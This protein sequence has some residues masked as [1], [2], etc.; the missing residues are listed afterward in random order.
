MSFPAKYGY[1][2]R[3]RIV[4]AVGFFFLFIVSYLVVKV[5]MFPPSDNDIS[6]QNNNFEV[7]GL[8]LP[9]NLNFC[10]EKLP[11]N[12]YGIKRALEKEFFNNIYWKF[13]SVILFNKAQRWFPIIE[14]ILKQEGVP[15]DFKYL[16]VIESH[17]SNATSPAGA[18]G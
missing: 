11:K 16:A 6:Y 2:A 14:P 1:F 15:Q 3:Y 4:L 12:D 13:N 7:L 18:A 9:A 17:L 8:N 5:F 10:G